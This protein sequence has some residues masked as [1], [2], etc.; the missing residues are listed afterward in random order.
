M[1]M[2]RQNNSCVFGPF[3]KSYGIAPS[4]NVSGVFLSKHGWHSEQGECFSEESHIS[5]L[6]GYVASEHFEQFTHD[7]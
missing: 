4:S 1:F 5:S 7:Q 2:K 3:C 6:D